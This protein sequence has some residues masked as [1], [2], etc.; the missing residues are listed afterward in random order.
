[1][2]DTNTAPTEP[3]ARRVGILVVHGIGEQARG[4]TMRQ[5]GEP[6]TDY[7]A[8]FCGARGATFDVDGHPVDDTD[9][10]DR[11][12]I[13]I[14]Q[15]DAHGSILIAESR[16][17]DSFRPSRLVTM[18]PWLARHGA[19]TLFVM[20]FAGVGALTNAAERPSTKPASKL[21]RGVLKT[22][23]RVLLAAA[24]LLAG[25]LSGILPVLL[26]LVTLGRL[27]KTTKKFADA[28]TLGIV[29]SV[30]DAYTFD[31][32]LVERA[33]MTKRLRMDLEW[34][35]SHVDSIQIVAHSLGS[36][37]TIEALQAESARANVSHITLLGNALAAV[38]VATRDCACHAAE[39]KADLLH[40]IPVLN[41][42]TAQDPVSIGKLVLKPGS[43]S[44]VTPRVDNQHSVIRDHTTYF[45]N[46]EQV[47]SL[48]AIQ[49]CADAGLDQ[50]VD[51]MRSRQSTAAVLRANRKDCESAA[52]AGSLLA[53]FAILTAATAALVG[54]AG[55]AIRRFEPARL[56][57]LPKSVERWGE[58]ILHWIGNHVPAT[59]GLIAAACI[60]VNAGVLLVCQEFDDRRAARRLVSNIECQYRWPGTTAAIWHAVLAAGAVAAH[61]VRLRLG[62]S[63]TLSTVG[64]AATA[65]AVVT[66]GYV[67]LS[68]HYSMSV[69][70]GTHTTTQAPAAA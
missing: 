48:I 28:L 57:V 60:A 7:L 33:A 30:G 67:A 47:L 68:N 29:S 22:I 58:T 25:T 9:G 49:A 50:L 17:S 53:I 55:A 66:A 44:F 35:R 20:S 5:V 24:L 70:A 19:R 26:L 64:L 59:A 56:K 52:T 13:S 2:T 18:I 21:A 37:L 8:E 10:P 62:G 61:F 46:A 6:L 51:V 65:G 14:S 1:M 36:A 42:A 41:L 12:T 40:G 4:T 69:N 45:S 23:A 11:C 43:S 31:K 32:K 3:A 38:D 54:S 15:G 63:T 16:W 39:L 34:M 27:N